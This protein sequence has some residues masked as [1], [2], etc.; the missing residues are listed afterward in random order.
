MATMENPLARCCM[1]LKRSISALKGQL[2]RYKNKLAAE[3]N[4]NAE[5]RELVEL[6][7]WANV[8]KLYIYI[9][10]TGTVHIQDS[11][12]ED[13]VWNYNSSLIEALRAA[14]KAVEGGK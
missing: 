5:A 14:K 2:T 13:V 7:E 11:E 12:G 3:Q 6:L 4:K 8:A 1:K 9:H 10:P